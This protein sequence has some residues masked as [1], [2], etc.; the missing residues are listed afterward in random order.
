[1]R[2]IMKTL[3]FLLAMVMLLSSLPMIASATTSQTEVVGK[4]YEFDKDSHYEFHEADT[5][6]T[7]ST[8]ITYGTFYINGN[9]ATNG[10]KS[11]VPSYEVADSGL[12]IYYNYVN[13]LYF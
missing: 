5:S 4:Y 3:Y 11:G 1:M 8:E 12:S 2:K 10:N 13:Y 9:I 7:T 6:E